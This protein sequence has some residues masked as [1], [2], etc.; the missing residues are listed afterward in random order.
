ME[1]ASKAGWEE[2]FGTQ[3][4][5]QDSLFPAPIVTAPGTEYTPSEAA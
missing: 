2:Q 1:T 3:N 4:A 5:D